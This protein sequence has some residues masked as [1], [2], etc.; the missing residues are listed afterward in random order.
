MGE[1]RSAAPAVRREHLRV[2]P[3]LD[4]SEVVFLA[5]FGRQPVTFHN[6]RQVETRTRVARI[7]PGQPAAPSP[8]VPCARGCCLEVTPQS[9]PGM[10]AQ[11]LRFL[12]DTFLAAEHSVS[13]V[14]D[15]GAAPG[16]PPC[17]VVVEDNDVFEGETDPEPAG[18]WDGEGPDA[19]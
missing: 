5:G 14:V 2:S 19:G 17:V 16:R 18:S 4:R 12:I 10:A 1:P 15:V 3:R 7:W 11:W 8:W 9:V 6:G 13:G